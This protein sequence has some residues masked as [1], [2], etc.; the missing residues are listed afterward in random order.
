M[1]M[2]IYSVKS[3]GRVVKA[4]IHEWLDR[5]EDR[6]MYGVQVKTEGQPHNFFCHAFDGEPLQP[7]LFADE[8]DAIQYKNELMAQAPRG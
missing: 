5:Q 3:G 7:V 8:Q 1:K 4:R 6:V 2:Y